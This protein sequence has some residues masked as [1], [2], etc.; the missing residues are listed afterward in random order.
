[1]NFAKL[2]G[3]KKEEVPREIAKLLEDTE[4]PDRL[5]DGID[6]LLAENDVR[7]QK[8]RNKAFELEGRRGLAVEK[9][10]SAELSERMEALTLDEIAKLEAQL[11]AFEGEMRILTRNIEALTGI[12]AKLREAKAMALK[13]FSEEQIEEI[14]L[15]HGEKKDEYMQAVNAADIDAEYDALKAEQDARRQALKARILA[16]KK[17][18]DEVKEAA[19]D[20]AP[21]TE[22]PATEAAAPQP[23]D[24][25]R[26]LELE[27]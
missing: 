13:G 7:L 4:D 18:R 19:A 24:D 20:E 23:A 14:I 12:Y 25:E 9:I 1:M 6:R 15:A 26:E 22:A 17:Q 10:E 21:R 8:A 11:D 16:G 5:L 3:R 27:G 2:F